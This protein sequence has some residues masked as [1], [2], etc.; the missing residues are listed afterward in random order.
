MDITFDMI[1]EI[2][3]WSTVAGIGL[4]IVLYLLFELWVY[5]RNNIDQ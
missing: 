3:K 4:S 2:L 5:Y 1:I